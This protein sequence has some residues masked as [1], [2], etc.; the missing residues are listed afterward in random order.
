MIV[1]GKTVSTG[2][3]AVP[4]A[5]S[6][7]VDIVQTFYFRELISAVVRKDRIDPLRVD[8]VDN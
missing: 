2:L 3:R 4:G 1:I 8:N 7:R 6:A 5:S